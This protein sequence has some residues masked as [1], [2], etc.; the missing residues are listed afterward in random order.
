MMGLNPSPAC[1]S[2]SNPGRD[3]N[4]RREFRNNLMR[5]LTIYVQAIQESKGR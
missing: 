3:A 4:R 2:R 5:G 1:L